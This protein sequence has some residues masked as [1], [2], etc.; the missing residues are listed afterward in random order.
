MPLVIR[1][2]I[3]QSVKIG[4]VTVKL[5]KISNRIAVLVIDAPASV[6]VLRSELL[7]KP[8]PKGEQ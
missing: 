5:D 1:R 2:R 8:K 6:R 4:D 7:D 3:G